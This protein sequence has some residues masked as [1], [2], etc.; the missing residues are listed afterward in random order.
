MR[1]Y[2]RYRWFCLKNLQI[3]GRDKILINLANPDK[4]WL[5]FDAIESEIGFADNSVTS[6][7]IVDLCSHEFGLETC[8]MHWCRVGDTLFSRKNVMKIFSHK[9]FSL[10]KLLPSKKRVLEGHK[11]LPARLII[12]FFVVKKLQCSSVP[13]CDN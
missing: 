12:N 4:F 10:H 7:S 5:T 3:R 2:Y 6:D 13:Q 8:L 9:I 11:Q 1:K